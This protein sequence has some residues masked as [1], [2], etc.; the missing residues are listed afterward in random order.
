MKKLIVL[1]YVLLMTVMMFAGCSDTSEETLSDTSSGAVET[2]N[3]EAVSNDETRSEILYTSAVS[4]QKLFEKKIDY[5][6]DS[7]KITKLLSNVK[8]GNAFYYKKGEFVSTD[9]F[10][11]IIINALP[12]Q[13][14]EGDAKKN[15]FDEAAFSSE[16][17]IVCIDNWTRNLFITDEAQDTNSVRTL[18]DLKG[19]TTELKLYCNP[20]SG[21]TAVSLEGDGHYSAYFYDL[22]LYEEIKHA[23]DTIDEIDEEGLVL[24]KDA[25]KLLD[26]SHQE[27]LQNEVNKGARSIDLKSLKKVWEFDADEA[28]TKGMVFDYNYVLDVEDLYTFNGAAGSMYLD[29]DMKI[30][31]VSFGQIAVVVREGEEPK[32]ARIIEIDGYISPDYMNEEEEEVMKGVVLRAVEKL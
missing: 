28:G 27:F 2:E 29:S 23:R 1:V 6:V 15:G 14:S 20:E 10:A 11:K 9:E 12:H 32:S 21:I 30:E 16:E 17:G 25:L 22:D 7:G 19:E 24:C 8:K 26:E 31:G 13:I 4:D 3:V 5:T 18:F